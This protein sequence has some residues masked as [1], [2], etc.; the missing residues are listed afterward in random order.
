MKLRKAEKLWWDL[1]SRKAYKHRWN[2]GEPAALA[3]AA[4]AASFYH[5]KAAVL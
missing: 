1:K 2:L 4:I 5:F 3:G